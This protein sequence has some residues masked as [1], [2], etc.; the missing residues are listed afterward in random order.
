[1]LKRSRIVPIVAAL[2]VGACSDSSTPSLVNEADITA[3]VATISGEAIAEHVGQLILNEQFAGLPGGVAPWSGP[4]DHPHGPGSPPGVDVTRSRTCFDQAGQPQAQCD[5]LTTA[6]VLLQVSMDGSFSR[7]AV[8]PSP[9]GPDTV[10]MTAMIHRDHELTI[11]GLLGTETSRTHNGHG[12]SNDTTTFAGSR[13][14]SRT[15]RESAVDS[16]KNVV[17]NLPRSTNPW[18]VEGQIVRVVTGTITVTHNGQ[19]EERAIDRR[20]VVTFPAD[21]QGNV[22]IQINDRTCTLNLVTR[23][24]VC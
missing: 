8:R 19:S 21:A 17:F 24:V 1:M 7:T 5:A 4:P 13:G 6:S 16:V 20:V 3:D 14:F 11:S 12:S 10:T 22:S 9:S 15:V 2:A 23:R 18:P